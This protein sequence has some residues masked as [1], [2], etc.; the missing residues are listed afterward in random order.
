MNMPTP[1]QKEIL[2]PHLII[3]SFKLEGPTGEAEITLTRLET[4]DIEVKMVTVKATGNVEGTS[5]VH[6]TYDRAISRA[7][8]HAYKLIDKRRIG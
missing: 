2:D 7:A 3:T 8:E 5:T 6:K 4:G 1:E